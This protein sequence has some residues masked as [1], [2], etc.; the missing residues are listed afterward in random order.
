MST[1]K[2]NS[3]SSKVQND[4]YAHAASTIKENVKA[5]GGKV[6]GVL[7]FSI[8]WNDI[9]SDLNDLDAHCVEPKEGKHKGKHIYFKRRVSRVTLGNLDIDIVVP[10]QE[11]AAVE[12]ITYP[13][14]KRLIKGKYIF[15]VHCYTS[16]RG[17]N[18]FRAEI[19]C[20]G[21]IYQYN[22]ADRIRD[23]QK[24]NV[25]MVYYDGDDFKIEHCLDPI[26][27]I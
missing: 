17:K 3:A 20:G 21:H 23:N 12:N 8:Q 6:D 5:A 27:I 13:N 24:V 19:E 7:R 16:R 25:A 26:K 14:K 18:G 22:Y 9:E 15:Y 2:K 11:A 1:I 4:V 10:A